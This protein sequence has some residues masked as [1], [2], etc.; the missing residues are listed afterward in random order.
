MRSRRFRRSRRIPTHHAFTEAT[1]LLAVS[2]A[3]FLA[4]GYL[5][6]DGIPALTAEG[7]GWLALFISTVRASA[8]LCGALQLRSHKSLVSGILGLILAATAHRLQDEAIDSDFAST[9]VRGSMLMLILIGSGLMA[10]GI[11]LLIEPN[12]AARDDRTIEDTIE[13]AKAGARVALF[14]FL[15]TFNLLVGVWRTMLYLV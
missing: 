2:V 14:V 9:A 15:L 4:P 1:W 7:A 8:E 5:P 6:L 11:S 10:N 13:G 12:P 3:L